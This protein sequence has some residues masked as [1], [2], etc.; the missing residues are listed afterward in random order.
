M[1]HRSLVAKELGAL[2][3][4]VSHPRRL[5][6]IE[7]L[8]GDERDVNALQLALGISHSGVSQHLAVLR[9]HRMVMERREGRHVFYRLCQPGLAGWLV[10]G[11]DFIEAHYGDADAIHNA[12]ASAK[13]AWIAPP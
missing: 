11:L 7:E 4:V 1:P 3:S 9:A 13:A 12:V 10:Q 8:Q 6:I 2:L 5:Q